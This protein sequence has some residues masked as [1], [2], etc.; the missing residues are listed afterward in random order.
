MAGGQH[1]AVCRCGDRSTLIGTL[2]TDLSEGEKDLE[3]AIASYE[4]KA[5]SGSYQRT[6]APVTPR[7]I[8][9]ARKKLESLG[10]VSALHRRRLASTD[11]TVANALFVHR[12]SAKVDADVFTNITEEAKVDPRRPRQGGH[13]DPD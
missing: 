1:P 2:L 7:M 6:T 10:Y 8:E 9:D 13:S 5:S 12:T 11:I 3:N 4:S